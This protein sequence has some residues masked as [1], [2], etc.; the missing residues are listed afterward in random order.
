MSHLYLPCKCGCG[1]LVQTKMENKRPDCGFSRGH[2]VPV[3]RPTT[4][5]PCECGCGSLVTTPNPYGRPTRFLPYHAK[6]LTSRPVKIVGDTALITLTRGK[7]SIIDACDLLL[8]GDGKW[9]A[10]KRNDGN[11]WYAVRIR[12]KK[13]IQMSRVIFGASAGDPIVDH[14]D[15]DGLNNRRSNLRFATGYQ[16]RVNVR[17]RKT[18]SSGFRGVVPAKRFGAWRA[19]IGCKGKGYSLGV[20]DSP[21]DAAKAYDH[22]AYHLHGEFAVLNFPEVAHA[23]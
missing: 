16:N 1:N 22:A 19:Q 6:I 20:F 4:Q 8:L 17:R 21:E 15:G 11:T 9:S 7:Y 12:D 23:S 14:I 13:I 10:L 2:F 3:P 18:G 5:V